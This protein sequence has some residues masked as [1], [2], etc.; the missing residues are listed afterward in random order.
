MPLLLPDL[1]CRDLAGGGGHRPVALENKHRKGATEQSLP[2]LGGAR[3]RRSRVDHFSAP[4]VP[5]DGSRPDRA[6]NTVE[7][8]AGNVGGAGGMDC[9]SMAVSPSPPTPLPN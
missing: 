5:D 6:L 9:K 7:C 4:G 8:A 1:Q 3:R 2:D